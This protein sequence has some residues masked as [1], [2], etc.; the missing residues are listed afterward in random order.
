MLVITYFPGKLSAPNRREQIASF[1]FCLLDRI[2]A[3]ERAADH[4]IVVQF[5]RLRAVRADSIDVRPR[6]EP[7][8]AQRRLARIG[9]GDNDARLARRRFR[10]IDPTQFVRCSAS[11][12]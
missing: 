6:R 4:G 2:Y 8:A 10:R 11:R 12:L 9:R 1:D 7:L 3:H 5:A